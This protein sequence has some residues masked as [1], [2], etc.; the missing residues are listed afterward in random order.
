MKQ[1]KE[2]S[3][4]YII[5][6]EPEECFDCNGVSLGMTDKRAIF[7]CISVGRGRYYRQA[8][9]SPQKGLRLLSF[10]TKK[11]A[12]KALEIT[13]SIFEEVWNIEPILL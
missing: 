12:M 10:K 4:Q 2:K 11:T 1:E 9:Y 6:S 8:L 13:N 7:Y 5:T 3:V